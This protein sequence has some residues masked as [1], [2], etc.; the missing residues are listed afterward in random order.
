MKIR[1]L[2][3]VLCHSFTLQGHHCDI[4]DKGRCDQGHHCVNSNIVQIGREPPNI[5]H[6]INYCRMTFNQSDAL[7][8]VRYIT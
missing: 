8:S 4:R 7:K 6:R 5:Q 1:T 2:R 3:A